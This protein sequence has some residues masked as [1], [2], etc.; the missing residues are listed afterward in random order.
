MLRQ[1]IGTRTEVVVALNRFTPR[2]GDRFCS[3]PTRRRDGG[4]EYTQCVS[5]FNANMEAAL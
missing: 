1:P 3:A 4:R 2:C 5:A